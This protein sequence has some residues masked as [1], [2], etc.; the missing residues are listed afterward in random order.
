M[1]ITGASRKSQHGPSLLQ[2]VPAG[3]CLSW[4][5]GFTYIIAVPKPHMIG[6]GLQR[7]E[8][9]TS[10]LAE[11]AG[12]GTLSTNH[13]SY[14]PSPGE[15][16]PGQYL[17]VSSHG[18]SLSLG[19]TGMAL[20]SLC[21]STGTS[22]GQRLGRS[23]TAEALQEHQKDS[24]SKPSPLSPAQAMFYTALTWRKPPMA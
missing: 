14:S 3:T 2:D 15:L 24:C 12:F 7:N 22:S 6:I 23:V 8:Q 13:R 10:H 1:V 5:K 21:L 9:E 18:S 19:S 11:E 20:T 16:S 17:Q 4:Q